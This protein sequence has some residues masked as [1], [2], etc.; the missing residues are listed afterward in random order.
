[1]FRLSRIN[2]WT[3]KVG[4]ATAAPLMGAEERAPR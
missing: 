1:M 3:G 2:C 4:L